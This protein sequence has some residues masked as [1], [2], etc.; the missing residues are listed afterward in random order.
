MLRKLS[1]RV[2]VVSHEQTV[3]HSLHNWEQQYRLK[4]CYQQIT[5][6]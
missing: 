2:C 5:F 1:T 4:N 3:G 6:R